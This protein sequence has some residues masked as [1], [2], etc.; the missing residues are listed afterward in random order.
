MRAVNN[1]I[2]KYPVTTAKQRLCNGYL[3]RFSPF[4]RKI[5]RRNPAGEDFSHD[6]EHKASRWPNV[7]KLI[8]GVI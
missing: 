6:F 4:E 2:Y 5:Y 8:D 3:L 7:T 1:E